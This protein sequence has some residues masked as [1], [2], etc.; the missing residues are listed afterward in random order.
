VKRSTK[1]LL[2]TVLGLILGLSAVPGHAQDG[3]RIKASIP[4]NFAVGNKELK[5]GDYVIQ[6]V[7][8]SGALTFRNEDTGDQQIAFAVPVESTET[9]NQESLIF[10]RYGDEYFLSQIWLSPN[11][12]HELVRGAQEKKVAANQAASA[13]AVAGQ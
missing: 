8:E 5:A 11:E 13:Q 10:D 3:P 7:R 1:Y 6:R 4:F 2:G 9:R 12:G